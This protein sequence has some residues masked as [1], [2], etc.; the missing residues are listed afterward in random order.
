MKFTWVIAM[1]TV[2]A[3]RLNIEEGEELVSIG[4][5]LRARG[6]DEEKLITGNRWRVRWP[7]GIT[8]PSDCDEFVLNMEGFP[9]KKK[10]ADAEIKYEW[11]LDPEIMSTVKTIQD[12][13]TK[14][15][16]KIPKSVWEDRA[17]KVLNSGP[18]AEKSWY[19]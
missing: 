6:I 9:K 7:E 8:D 2:G 17:T 14:E 18:K 19:L 10:K 11:Q 3:R 4:E 12:V 13:E 1:A 15:G 5:A 16:K